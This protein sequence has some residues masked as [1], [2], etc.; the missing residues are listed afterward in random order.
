LK[1]GC[2]RERNRNDGSRIVGGG[3]KGGRGGGVWGSGVRTNDTGEWGKGRDMV[4]GFPQAGA[5]FAIK[6]RECKAG[7]ERPTR[8][9][10]PRS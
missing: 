7:L 10:R 3:K 5:K 8:R 4:G 6:L 1:E 2:R 9:K